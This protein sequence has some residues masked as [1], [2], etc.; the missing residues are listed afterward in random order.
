M[1]AKFDRKFILILSVSAIAAVVVLGVAL[2]I[3]QPWGPA[4]HLRRA[5][6]A[7]A[8]GEWRQA[9]A[10]YGRAFGKE[11]GNVSFLDLTRD[12][13]LRIVPETATEASERYQTLRSILDRGTR[14]GS[15]DPERWRTYLEFIEEQAIALD[16]SGSWNALAEQA[17]LMADSFGS[18]D[19][20]RDLA[21]EF[22]CFALAQRLDALRSDELETLEGD[23]EAL[24][25]LRPQSDRV[26][27]TL[28]RLRALDGIGLAGSGRR[29]EAADRLAEAQE[30]LEAAAEANATGPEL[31]LAQ[32]ELA[33]F[34][35][36]IGE[37]DPLEIDA[38]IESIGEAASEVG[39]YPSLRLARAML[40]A[41][42]VEALA[43]VDEVL[44]GHLASNPDDLFHAQLLAF[45]RQG[46]DR[47]GG[48]E[49]AASLLERPRLSVG[50]TA[51]FQDEIALRAA[52]QIFDVDFGDWSR[53]TSAE[54][55]ELAVDR[56][57]KGL[58]QIERLTAG[59]SD[60]SLRLR[61]EA[62]LALARNN[63]A[64]AAAR[65]E[66]VLRRG[67]FD[68]AD[69]LYHAAM[70]L[71]QIGEVGR[72]Y[73]LLEGVVAR[74]PDNVLLLGLLGEIAIQTGRNDEAERFAARILEIDPQ[75]AG[76]RRLAEAAVQR[77]GLAVGVA[78][79]P[80]SLRLKAAESLYAAGRL[81]DARR[82]L[83]EGREAF[84]DDVRFLRAEAQVALRE[85][86]VDEA[87][88][89]V[90]VALEMDP[91][92]AT[93][94]R[95]RSLLATEDPI[96]RIRLLTE[97]THAGDPD[98][99]SRLFAAFEAARREFQRKSEELLDGDPEAARRF[100]ELA[101][102]AADAAQEARAELGEGEAVP[103][104][105][106]SRFDEAVRA[107]DFDAAL[108]IADD[109]VALGDPSVRPLLRSRLRL[110]Q[111]DPAAA[112]EEIDDALE[113]GVVNSRIHRQR[114]ALLE[115]LGR[116][117]EALRAY[118]EALSRRPDDLDTIRRRAGLLVRAGRNSEALQTLRDARRIAMQDSQIEEAWLTLEGQFGDRR[119]ALERRAER[120]QFDRED[121]ANALGLA[122]LLVE[123]TPQRTDVKDRQGRVRFGVGQWESLSPVERQEELAE[124]ERTWRNGAVEI[125]TAL[126]AANPDDLQIAASRAGALRKLGRAADGERIL[127]SFI[128]SQGADATAEAWLALGGFLVESR[129]GAEALAAFDRAVEIEDPATRPASLFLADFW[130]RRAEWERALGHLEDV[131]PARESTL[132]RSECLT[133]LGRLA[134]AESLLAAL[135]DR[136]TTSIL[137]EAAI[138]EARGRQAMQDSQA[139]AAT[140]AYQR[141]EA[142][143][144]EARTLSPSNPQPLVQQ[145]NSLRVRGLMSGDR[146][147]LQRAVET[148]DEALRLD[149][150]SWAA[151]RLRSEV[152]IEMGDALGAAAGLEEFVARQP[153][154][155]EARQALVEAQLRADN[156]DRATEVVREAIAA[157]PNDAAWHQSLGELSLRERR[158]AD[159][160]ESFRRSYE[161][162]PNPSTLHRVVDMQLR[163]NPPDYAGI[164]EVLEG[165]ENDVERSVYLQSAEAVAIANTGD[166]EAGRRELAE[167]Y[168][169]AIEAI[170]DGRG[171]PSVLDGWFANL[172]FL[173]GP[174]DVEQAEAFVRTAADVPVHPIGLR[175][176]A[177]LAAAAGESGFPR[178]ASLLEE[179][180]ATDDG[181]DPRT[182]ARLHL[183]RGNLHYVSG[184]CRAAIESFERSAASGPPN[185]QTLNNLAF[186]CGDCL[187]DP[188]RGLPHIER[189]MAVADRV[190]E[191]I[192]TYG[193][194]L[195]K[196]GRL[197]EAETNLLRSLRLRPT[198]LANYHLAE[199]LAAKGNPAQA[200]TAIQQARDLDPDPDLAASIDDLEQRIR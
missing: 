192:D 131:P 112:L 20:A 36:G 30:T 190:P 59:A 188:E 95:M 161:L 106:A 146:L 196:A 116:P 148:I 113:A 119:L 167:S 97:Q 48:R 184:D 117:V 150:G 57:V 70:A 137:L 103:A 193:F 173:Y 132:R 159:A 25:S 10:F 175:W 114:G 80:A 35:V 40:G 172:R 169:Y 160:L 69:T 181:S 79:D 54:E 133:R 13:L 50:L 155:K 118:E 88:E 135:E 4:R 68:D 52:A 99:S 83:A 37:A 139:E 29:L 65:F 127:R 2:A 100:S 44:E 200:R 187:D 180:I 183:D 24:T 189:A 78:D 86:N 56:M 1:A 154:L 47:E 9:F 109:A 14:V 191:F 107:G 8:E 23:L 156:V 151:T 67:R 85:G 199:V 179:A 165:A 19:P 164:L 144:A 38:L 121:T 94:I 21:E 194:L 39:G 141:F 178:A 43:R 149:A 12:A 153:D 171:D 147:M 3:L 128:A 104:L 126:A 152:L 142:L 130:F 166:E 72:A 31:L 102:R 73:Q 17:E 197:D 90:D 81:E 115:A 55:R 123:L 134:E 27:G 110:I 16:D 74:Q 145:A 168:R 64:L 28:A 125:F 120:Y 111:G 163:Q 26:W 108:A 33:K 11:P 157:A 66:E 93:L 89:L 185:P 22:R 176:L 91:R 182:T 32:L 45:V 162:A 34:R 101:I 77:E 82:T 18:G 136:D 60:D 42:R 58:G 174:E 105:I 170:A 6:A 84:P 5:E 198:A 71:R 53:A 7:A 138:A 186:L 49:I 76:G 61:C 46:I 143:I 140:D 15:A 177:E 195:W 129:K 122:N 63:A 51:A 75:N 41:G 62:K 92:D 87:R 98:L 96:E 158:F 124:V